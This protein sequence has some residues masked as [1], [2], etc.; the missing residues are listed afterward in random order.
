MINTNTYR[1]QRK[2]G[3]GGGGGRIKKKKKKK[4]TPPRCVLILDDV[5]M[6]IKLFGLNGIKADRAYTDMD[7]FVQT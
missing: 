5:E 2:G 1:C 6:F 3:G 4:K 7:I